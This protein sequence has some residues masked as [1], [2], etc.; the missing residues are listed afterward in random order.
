[1]HLQYE[2]DQLKVANADLER[3]R[4]S[5]A[6]S[7]GDLRQQLA[8]AVAET[9]LIKKKLESAQEELERVQKEKENTQASL[10]SQEAAVIELK[11]LLAQQAASAPTHHESEKLLQNAVE[12]FRTEN[13]TL[14][15]S[16]D[17]HCE[18]ERKLRQELETRAAELSRV[19]IESER[20][21]M[22]LEGKEYCNIIVSS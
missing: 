22:M 8:V 21:G 4:R 15:K 18:N 19:H 2:V 3:R 5:R 6:N 20:A 14:K 1:M 13:E 7:Q 9:E 12:Q 17:E 11:Q 16:L 10:A